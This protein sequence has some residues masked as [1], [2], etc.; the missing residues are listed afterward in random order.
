M[1]NLDRNT[2][3][4]VTT[5]DLVQAGA[6][7][8]DATRLLDGGLWNA[9]NANNQNPY[10]GMFTT[11]LHAEAADIAAILT[12]GSYTAGGTTVQLTTQD[13]AALNDVQTQINDMLVQAGHAVGN[14]PGAIAAQ[15][16]LH[17][18]DLAVLNDINN[19][20]T[21]ATALANNQYG[22]N[23]GANDAGFQALPVGADNAVAL[24]GATSTAATLA[25]VGNVFNAATDLAVGGLHSTNL[26]EFNN[27]MQAV[28]TGLAN[29]LASPN[30]LMTIETGETAD[31]A[32]LTTIHLQTVLNQINEQINQF[33]PE[34]ASNPNIAARSTNDNL[35]DIIDII[36]GD[37][38]LNTAAGGNG[39]AGHEGGF[40][41]VAG[42]LS[43]TIT[44]YQDNQAQTNFWAQFLAEANTG[45]AQLN[46]AA[47]GGESV[48]Q[49]QALVSQLQAYQNF[50]ADFAQSQG[51]I[52]GA[53]FDNELLS[54][55][56]LADTNAAVTALND[57][58]AN[59]GVVSAADA[60]MMHAAGSGFQA[61]AMDVSGN[62]VPIGGGSYVGTATTVATA[63]SPNGVAMG[64]IPVQAGPSSGGGGATS[65]TG[66]SPGAPGPGPGS[67]HH[68]GDPGP[69]PAA[70]EHQHHFEH[71]WHHV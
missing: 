21:L 59:N 10:Q 17:A 22:A 66:T 1:V 2:G 67:S 48:A 23:T 36:Q 32:A 13:T 20:T 33:D 50:G 44:K 64:S 51:G 31:A 25:D 65:G 52:F 46:T 71:I 54:G 40:S 43:G 58:I 16:A 26:A 35:L 14:G 11:D 4:L 7:F 6:V 28:A 24:A 56:L 3:A 9:P 49:L 70:G 29:I 41:E 12:A 19:D 38:N 62:N 60:A 39:M 37:A 47:A 8:N 15:A 53:R 55:T 18:D 42:Y 63:T 34:Y 69:G 30:E 27:D 61:D 45:A 5:T 68:A 57:A